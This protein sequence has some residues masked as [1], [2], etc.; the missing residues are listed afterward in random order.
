VPRVVHPWTWPR[1]LRDHGPRSADDR[2]FILA[3]LALHTFVDGDSGTTYVGV[4]KWA[5]AARMSVNT[6]MPL[7]ERAV[8]E[9]W[10]HLS[11]AA[12]AARKSAK[13]VYR[14]TVPEHVPLTEKD[15]SLRDI[16][17]STFGEV[18]PARTVSPHG[19]DTVSRSRLKTVSPHG[20]DTD[21]ATCGYP[22]GQVASPA[23]SVSAERPNCVSGDSKLCQSDSKLCEPRT[24]T[25]GIR[26][27][28]EEVCVKVHA[29]ARS[30]DDEQE[31][32]KAEQ[33]KRMS[34]MD[35]IERLCV[36][37]SLAGFPLNTTTLEDVQV[38]EGRT[39]ASH[40]D[41][42]AAIRLL[43]DSGRLPLK[44]RGLTRRLPDIV[45]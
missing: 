26:S 28:S 22:A 21:G 16:I 36:E 34:L 17:L 6:L 38:L 1:A 40:Q 37:Y 3:L 23:K 42:M 2:N 12:G 9:G 41:V 19:A 11:S 29:D 20:A 43:T 30:A 18:P 45:T 24:D 4:R 33:A 10:V 39:K 13:S 32:A 14:L 15:E 44:R 25:E 31:R 27:S 35:S 5:A 8:A 7:R